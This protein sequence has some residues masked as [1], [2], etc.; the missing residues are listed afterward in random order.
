ML[1]GRGDGD[2]VSRFPMFLLRGGSFSGQD[3]GTGAGPFHVSAN[4]GLG[5][6]APD[7]GFRGAR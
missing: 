4:D 5:N 1:T 6:T 7:Y 2:S 3:S